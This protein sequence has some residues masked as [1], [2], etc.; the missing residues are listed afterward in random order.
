[1]ETN[2][3]N[4]KSNQKILKL[5]EDKKYITAEKELLNVIKEK[6]EDYQTHY[7]LGNIYALLKKQEK[8]IEQYNLS[9]KLNSSN[10]VTHYNLGIMFDELGQIQNAQNSFENALK[11]DSE[12]LHAN[13]AMALNLEKQNDIK[14]ARFF[15][16]KTLSIKKDFILAHERYAKFLQKIGDITKCQYHTYKYAG[17]ISFNQK[18]NQ[19]N[20][21]QRLDDFQ[22]INFIGCWNINN[23]NLCSK[24]IEFF[25]KRKD[26][27]KIGEAYSGKDEKV[28]KSIDI[29]VHPR[30][31]NQKGFEDIKL[32]MEYLHECHE[33]YKSQ[34]PFIRNNLNNLHIPSFNIQKYEKGGHFNQ[35]H[36]ER[37]SPR[38]MHRV[39]A[40]MTYLNDVDDGGAT[41]F[42]HYKLRIKP[43]KGKTLIWP[44]E[45]TH[46]HR[47]EVLTKGLKYIVTGWMHFP[48]HFKS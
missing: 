40:W 10:K 26:L 6:K 25:E 29:T 48:F 9:N 38:S 28:K 41:Y 16:E 31:L 27:Q 24:I 20:K 33:D 32:Y 45:W 3:N 4:I 39:F 13:F 42:E 21:V 5:I 19:N 35:M 23:N 18:K 30:D 15:F 36:C 46:A 12:Y 47:G 8:A 14:K 34:W 7:L 43:I 11:L 2:Q 22:D 37:G 17:I 44:A 1:M